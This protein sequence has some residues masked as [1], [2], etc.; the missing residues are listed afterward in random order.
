MNKYEKKIIRQKNTIAELTARLENAAI[1]FKDRENQ[2][3]HEI[4]EVKDASPI[5]VR[6]K[7][8]GTKQ[9]TSSQRDPGEKKE[10]GQEGD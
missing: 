7:P 5:I 4:Q 3:I 6:K 10:S 8:E 2:L 9:E 1:E